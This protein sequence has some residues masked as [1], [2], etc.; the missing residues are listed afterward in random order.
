MDAGPD[1]LLGVDRDAGGAE[2]VMLLR[3]RRS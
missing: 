3:V 2:R 1:W